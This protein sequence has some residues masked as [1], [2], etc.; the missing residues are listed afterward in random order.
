MSRDDN[1]LASEEK[2]QN[3]WEKW[4][5]GDES[6][7]PNWLVK[8]PLRDESLIQNW[9]EEWASSDE[10]AIQNWWE[11][12]SLN[13]EGDD[14]EIQL[15]DRHLDQAIEMLNGNLDDE[16]NTVIKPTEIAENFDEMIAA[17][18]KKLGQEVIQKVKKQI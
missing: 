8:W 3:L 15:Y 11:E 13:D 18:L 17:D 7:F 5:S 9:W 16:I 14:Y 12:W 6:I 1:R 10:S 2:I 4:L